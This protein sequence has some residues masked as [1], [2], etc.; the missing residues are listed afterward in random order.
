MRFALVLS[1]TRMWDASAIAGPA[2]SDGACPATALY[3]GGKEYGVISG[4]P[5][6]SSPGCAM[7]AARK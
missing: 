5:T 1:L 4:L 3:G 7:I 6:P 2:T